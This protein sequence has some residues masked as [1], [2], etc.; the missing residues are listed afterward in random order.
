MPNAAARRAKDV[1]RRD[2]N[3]GDVGDTRRAR[4]PGR[5]ARV[6]VVGDVGL[7]LGA[8]DRRISGTIDDCGGR[9]LRNIS[10]DVA[11]VGEIKRV[12]F[13]EGY[14]Y[15]LWP[16]VTRQLPSDLALAT[17]DEDCLRHFR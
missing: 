15:T 10:F 6:D 4:Q 1:V 16:S 8:V 12:A 3:H 5:A 9:Y 7:V 2:V 13:G 17:G 11:A 14:I